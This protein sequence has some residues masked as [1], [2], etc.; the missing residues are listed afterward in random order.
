MA[1]VK[2]KKPSKK[3]EGKATKKADDAKDEKKT[4]RPI[5]DK[6]RAYASVVSFFKYFGGGFL[7]WS[8]GRWDFDYYWMLFGIFGYTL[9]KC[10]V[11]DQKK[12]KDNTE[13]E[14]FVDV[15]DVSRLNDLPSWVST[16]WHWI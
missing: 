15:N 1:E 4:G 13:S 5:T 10:Y 14:V 9:W 12:G 6:I 2:E 8:F 3:P 11:K 7:V 16:I